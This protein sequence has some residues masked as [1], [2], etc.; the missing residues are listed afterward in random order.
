MQPQESS[1]SFYQEQLWQPSEDELFIALKEEIKKDKEALEM[2]LPN[3]EPT[4]DANMV[5]N[6]DTNSKNINREMYAIME[7]VETHAEELEKL[8]KEQSPRQLPSYIKNDDI[9]ESKIIYLS[10][11]EELSSPTLDED[12]NIIESD[13]MPMLMLKSSK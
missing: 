1:S 2:Q 6:I 5:A 10:L 12:K 8:L 4:V 7:R 13:K 3:I 11:G 9:W